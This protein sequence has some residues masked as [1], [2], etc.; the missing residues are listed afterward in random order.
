[1]CN[2][3]IIADLCINER[4]DLVDFLFGKKLY[5][6]YNKMSNLNKNVTYIS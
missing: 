1:M 4:G 2:F 6:V 5:P 3:I